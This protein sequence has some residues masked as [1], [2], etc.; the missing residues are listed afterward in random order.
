MTGHQQFF[1]IEAHRYPKAVAV[2]FLAGDN[3]VAAPVLAC[4]ILNRFR[5]H[6]FPFVLCDAGWYRGCLKLNPPSRRLLSASSD[7]LVPEENAKL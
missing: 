1:A 5:Q 2:P 7:T 4:L 3:Y 6:G